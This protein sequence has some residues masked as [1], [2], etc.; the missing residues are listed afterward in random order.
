MSRRV[1][2]PAGILLLL[3]VLWA[4]VANFGAQD[5][6][7]KVTANGNDLIISHSGEPLANVV[8]TIN[9]QHRIEIGEVAAGER[10]YSDDHLS[11][12]THMTY[13]DGI[14]ISTIELNASREGRAINIHSMY[15][16]VDRR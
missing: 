6:N 3:I 10:R 5:S 8:L 16:T 1:L 14:P 13:Y 4:V 2:V 11:G 9:G 12:D 15:V 7:I